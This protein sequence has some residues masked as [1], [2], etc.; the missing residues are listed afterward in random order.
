VT[1]NVTVRYSIDEDFVADPRIDC[2]NM[3][4][5]LARYARTVTR[6][7]LSRFNLADLT[8][9]TTMNPAPAATVNAS[10]AREM[11]SYHFSIQRV[12]LYL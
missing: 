7:E 4:D 5:L 10:L 8:N 9:L 1:A 6:D 2:G 11:A 12:D 3:T